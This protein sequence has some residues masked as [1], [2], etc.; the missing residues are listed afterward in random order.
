MGK[1]FWTE[2]EQM[3]IVWY[4]TDT[5]LIRKTKKRT[6]ERMKIKEDIVKKAL[7]DP[8]FKGRLQ[9]KKP[10]N[11][12]MQHINEWV[13]HFEDGKEKPPLKK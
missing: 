8:D 5:E 11:T 10:K 12:I 4:I 9:S 7:S 3:K 2:N 1:P 13:K 6:S